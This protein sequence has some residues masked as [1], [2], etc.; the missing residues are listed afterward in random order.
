MKMTLLQHYCDS[1]SLNEKQ[2]LSS[3]IN[4]M[5]CAVIV[6]Y[7]NKCIYLMNPA[8]EILTGWRQDEAIGRNLTEVVSLVDKDQDQKIDKLAAQ[9]MKTGETLQLPENCILIARNG[10]KI[11]IGDTIAPLRDHEGNINGTVLVL[12]D[13]SQ[14]K[15]LEE[16]LVRNAFYDPLTAL[17]NRL[18]F[19]DRLRQAIERSKR[20]SNYQFAVLFVDLDDF[21]KINDRF[22]HGI[23]DD[24]L[25]FVARCLESCLR[26][27]DTVARLGGDEFVIFLDDIQSISDAIHIVKRIQESLQVPI[28]LNDNKIS[29]TASIGIALSCIHHQEPATILRDAD[30]AMYQAKRQG[31][32]QYMVFDYSDRYLQIQHLRDVS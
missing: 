22:G 12:Q 14:R 3:I 8:A 30:M 27:S 11:P 15:Q 19:Q 31:K 1:K 13:I 25:V 32:G 9:V 5:A 16:K 24:Y 7:T 4:S 20:R 21:K 29:T 18:L 6:T 10:Q 23:G 2:I 28:H 26:S 17:P